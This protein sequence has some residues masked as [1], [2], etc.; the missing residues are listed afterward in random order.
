MLQASSGSS[1]L[2]DA[3]TDKPCHG[4]EWHSRADDFQDLL[5]HEARPQSNIVISKYAKLLYIAK[6]A[7][8]TVIR[9]KRI[10]QFSHIKGG[11]NIESE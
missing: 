1:G 10:Y 11:A 9:I 6:Q 4:Q 8:Y 2:S 7:V 3:S 5:Y